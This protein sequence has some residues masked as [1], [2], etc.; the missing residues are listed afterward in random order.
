MVDEM[1]D[2]SLKPELKDMKK[3][4]RKPEG[5]KSYDLDNVQKKYNENEVPSL[6][7]EKQTIEE[8]K[9]QSTDNHS[10]PNNVESYIINDNISKH[11]EPIKKVVPHFVFYFV[12]FLFLYKVAKRFSSRPLIKTLHWL[13]TLKSL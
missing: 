8:I 6:E 11:S 9:G 5:K 13:I 7:S 1:T 12:F 3:K 10:N 2:G 4:R